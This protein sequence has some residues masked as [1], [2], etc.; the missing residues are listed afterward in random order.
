MQKR[1]TTFKTSSARTTS[2]AQAVRRAN[3][4]RF[5]LLAAAFL[6]TSGARAPE[7]SVAVTTILAAYD[8]ATHAEDVDTLES[9]GTI[10]G[11]GLTGD[12]HTWRAQ[13]NERDDERLG[14]RYET[15]LRLGNRVY[16]RDQSGNV[17]EL[18]GYL[19]RRQL[20]ADFVDS[21]AFLKAP[22]RSTFL[23]FGMIG[24]ARAWRLQVAARGG[25]PET[26]WIDAATGMP[27]RLEYLDGDGA[28]TVD[29]YDWRTVNGRMFP[30][31]TVTSDGDRAFDI[32]EQTTS[33]T[34][35][36]PIAP[37]TFASLHN[38]TIA[39]TGVQTVPLLESGQH[40]ACK[41]AI[42]GEPATFLIDTGA[43]SVVLDDRLTKRLDLKGEGTLE[44]R[45]ATRTGGL[46]VVTIPHLTVGTGALDHLVAASIDLGGSTDGLVRVDGI[47]GFPFF[48]S[49]LVELDFAHHTM[50][51]GAPG[52]FVP[53]GE[54]IDLD[55]DRG[56]IE[57][58]FE[59]NNTLHAP[60]IVDTG[61]SGELLLYRPFIVANPGVAPLT[62]KSSR[63]FGIGGS[64]PAQLSTIDALGLGSISL[65]HVAAT[66]IMS[67]KGAFADHVDAGN[68][69][70]G[71][72]RNFIV[73][74]DLANSAMY[75]EKSDAFDDGRRR[76]ATTS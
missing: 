38:R 33:L 39:A 47:L 6:V 53:R 32:V 58:S 27:L 20:T 67:D 72:L 31:R 11:E 63:T 36:R 70:L 2:I 73:T 48:A 19:K 45:G 74:F 40:I 7:P 12:F 21:G 60:F 4:V 43:Q 76:P 16:L 41:V 52:A 5:G 54:K 50:R 30:F 75:L 61:N 46:S 49:S 44:V 68:V 35:D 10:A 9:S 55:L 57:A 23:G 59:L 37:E 15:T 71:V 28:S 69:G 56:I 66:L 42:D 65:Y 3:V 24:A 8:R 1:R 18:T 22:E 14:P 29:F 25:E 26:L 13:A 17:R 51:F 64:T 34:I 62:G